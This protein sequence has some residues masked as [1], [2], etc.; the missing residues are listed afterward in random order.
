MFGESCRRPE[1]VADWIACSGRRGSCRCISCCR[2]DKTS[3]FCEGKDCN[4]F[5]LII[6]LSAAVADCGGPE[7]GSVVMSEEVSEREKKNLR[8]LTKVF[9][10]KGPLDECLDERCYRQA[11]RSD[12]L[13]Q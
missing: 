5:R 1:S 2:D 7:R 13:V 12:E 6:N 4:G 3:S 10:F 11:F 8:S 9:Q